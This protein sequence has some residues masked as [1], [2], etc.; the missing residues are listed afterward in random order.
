MGV[1]LLG[2]VGFPRQVVMAMR[3]RMAS[4]S[5]SSVQVL[6]DSESIIPGRRCNKWKMSKRQRFRDLEGVQRARGGSETV[7]VL[8][9]GAMQGERQQHPQEVVLRGCGRLML[10]PLRAWESCQGLKQ[11]QRFPVCSWG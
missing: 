8:L 11:G 1:S 2:F 4:A 10:C 3:A 5:L 9:E 7:L 6:K